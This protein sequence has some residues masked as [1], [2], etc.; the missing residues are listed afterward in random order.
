M[1]VFPSTLWLRA[2]WSLTSPT[3]AHTL[4]SG[5][6]KLLSRR[7][8]NPRTHVGVIHSIVPLCLARW[9]DTQQTLYF[10]ICT[11]IWTVKVKLSR[12]T[13][14]RR[15][16]GRRYSFYSFSISA[17]DWGEWS[18]SRP[19][20][21][22]PQGKGPPVPTVQEAGW[23]PELVWTQ[24]IEEKPS[25]S[26]GDRTPVVQSVVRHYTDWA[27][28]APRYEQYLKA[29]VGC[30]GLRTYQRGRYHTSLIV[31]NYKR[32]SMDLLIVLKTHFYTSVYSE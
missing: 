3:R 24:R 23:T 30:M 6:M 4:D 26:V 14:W 25:A 28:P 2:G 22:L 11:E 15:L 19:G 17:L 12:Y 9:T 32:G 7:P 31:L 1:H 10:L 8:H 20:R 16:E 27:T 21:A 18:A 13:P 5:C 29:E